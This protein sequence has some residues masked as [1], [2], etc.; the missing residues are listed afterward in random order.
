[1]ECQ[2]SAK[3]SF[4]DFPSRTILIIIV[5]RGTKIKDTFSNFLYLIWLY[6]ISCR[7]HDHQHFSI[8]TVYVG[9][10]IP[11][12]LKIHPRKCY[13][14]FEFSKGMFERSRVYGFT[15]FC[16]ID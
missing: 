14:K 11:T 13:V 7:S 15:G 1:M 6:K 2:G 4:K 10:I 3:V 9:L 8:R 5:V 16:L 12:F